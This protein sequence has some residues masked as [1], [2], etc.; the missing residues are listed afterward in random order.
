MLQKINMNLNQPGFINADTIS[1][2]KFYQ[3][4]GMDFQNILCRL[5][6][7]INRSPGESQACVYNLIPAVYPDNSKRNP[8]KKHMDRGINFAV[9]SLNQEQAFI[10]R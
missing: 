7:H 8:H 9:A 6:W 3:T 2:A 4:A 10:F 5:P 1:F